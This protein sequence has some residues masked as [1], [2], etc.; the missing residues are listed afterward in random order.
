MPFP[1]ES[2]N[3][4]PVLNNNEYLIELVLGIK[5]I[6]MMTI[7]LKIEITSN[8]DHNLQVHATSFLFLKRGKVNI[9]SQNNDNAWNPIANAIN[10]IPRLEYTSETNI[11]IPMTNDNRRAIIG[12]VRSVVLCLGTRSVFFSLLKRFFTLLDILL[13]NELLGRG[14]DVELSFSLSV[15]RRASIGSMKDRIFSILTPFLAP[16]TA[17][18]KSALVPSPDL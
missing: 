4:S 14:F 16:P 18:K 8:N 12:G 6:P 17:S 15:S 2:Q 13:I 5:S 9:S 7:E 11:P 10:K 1:L 3:G